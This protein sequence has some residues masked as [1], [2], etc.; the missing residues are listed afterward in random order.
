MKVSNI[1]EAIAASIKQEEIQAAKN[2]V[3][4]LTHEVAGPLVM[5]ALD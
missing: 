5:I 2:S 4:K 3:S 1:I